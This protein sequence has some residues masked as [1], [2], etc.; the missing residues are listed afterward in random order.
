MPPEA[1]AASIRS[2][3]GLVARPHGG[4]LT[5]GEHAF[6]AACAAGWDCG[7]I[8]RASRPIPGD[9]RFE[10]VVVDCTRREIDANAVDAAWRSTRPG[11]TLVLGACSTGNGIDRARRAVIRTLGDRVTWRREPWS[12]AM[13]S[14]A[15]RVLGWTA[16]RS[17]VGMFPAD[18]EIIGRVPVPGWEV[19]ASVLGI[20]AD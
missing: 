18:A 15:K 17:P 12:P 9:A 8:L 19:D 10:A 4:I 3:I 1:V 20:D 6:R 16:A 5:I 2:G 13:L 7:R 14:N 11:G